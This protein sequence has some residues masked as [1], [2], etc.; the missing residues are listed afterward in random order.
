M[1]LN[2]KKPTALASLTATYTDS[3][4]EP[5]SEEEISPEVS[6]Y[7]VPVKEIAPI[8]IVPAPE[9]NE[10]IARKQISKLISYSEGTIDDADE[11]EDSDFEER[12]NSDDSMEDDEKLNDLDTWQYSPTSFHKSLLSLKPEEV[13]LP[14]APRGRCSNSL[15]EKIAELYEKKMKEGKDMNATIQ[16]KKN[17]R[18]PSI[19]E[20]LINYC[21]IDELGTNYPPEIY[22]QHNWGPESFYDQLAKRQKEEM[23]KREKEK[24]ERTKVEFISG[25]VKK[26]ADVPKEMK[27]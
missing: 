10:N 26:T 5:D 24:K 18:N 11:K 12:A 25:T 16:K 20:K 22:N 19:Y 27:L 6:N 9:V 8:P 21:G 2:I 1:S 13:Q 17:F 4:G 15:Q 14:P 23:E 7:I 3:E